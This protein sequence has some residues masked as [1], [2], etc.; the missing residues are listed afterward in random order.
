MMANPPVGPLQYG[1]KG[2]LLEPRPVC[3]D[4]A[5]S[6]P[7]GLGRP[8]Q[9]IGFEQTIRT[10]ELVPHLLFIRRYAQEP[11]KSHQGFQAAVGLGGINTVSRPSGFVRR[12]SL[13]IFRRQ[14]PLASLAGDTGIQT[15][16]G[17]FP[18]PAA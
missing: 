16:H 10:A 5:A 11:Q 2:S 6:Q 4:D 8:H 1:R 17:R 15:I 7:E 14:Q 12:R 9:V 18:P 3:L 13:G